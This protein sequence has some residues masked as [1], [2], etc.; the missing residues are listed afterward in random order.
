MTLLVSRVSR[1][2]LSLHKVQ[3]APAKFPVLH[4]KRSKFST[5]RCVCALKVEKEKK[6]RSDLRINVLGRAIEDD[7][8]TI[9]ENYGL[10]TTA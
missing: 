6:I 10:S 8:A 7:F 9:R 1:A 5:S 3:A 2:R 4:T